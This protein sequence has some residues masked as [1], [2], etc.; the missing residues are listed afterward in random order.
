MNTLNPK[1]IFLKTQAEG[2]AKELS[3]QAAGGWLPLSLSYA[4][5]QTATIGATAE[6]LQG[7]RRFVTTFLNL[8]DK[9]EKPPALPDKSD[10]PSYE[11]P[12]P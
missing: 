2:A 8:G 4:L 10:L 6:E 7:I 9:D 3:M 1:A 12:Q 11:P 5:A